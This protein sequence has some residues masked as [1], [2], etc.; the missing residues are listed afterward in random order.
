MSNYVII[1][2][3]SCDLAPETLKEW[4]VESINLT[5]HLDGSS[6]EYINSDM[7]SGVFYQRMREGS[8]F[9]TAA[10]NMEDFCQVFEQKLQ[11]GVDILYLG[12]SS[13]LSNTVCAGQM[14]ATELMEK[15][16]ER[17][18]TVIDTLCASAGQGMVVYLAVQKKQSGASMEEVA[19]YVNG[20][21]PNLCHWFTV[22]D[23]VYLK[24][25]GRVSAATALLGGILNI[26]PILHVDDEG[27][28]ISMSKVRGRRQSIQAL[29]KKYEETALSPENGPYFISHGDCMDDAKA[30]ENCIF[31]KYGVKA[32]LIADIGPVIGS[33]SGPGT[34]ALF[35]LGRNR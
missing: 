15:Y 21:L 27:H 8:V 3:S 7:P 26:K 1:T 35:F 6:Q 14:A 12:F 20:L 9:K 28:L 19:A 10:A 34:L 18:I 25:G 32:T 2:D 16:P 23:L 29:A 4:S 11:E 22:D 31:E 33:H 13:G 30:L 24:R 5:F 17:R